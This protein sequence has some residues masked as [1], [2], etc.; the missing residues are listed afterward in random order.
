[1]HTIERIY[2]DLSECKRMGLEILG[3]DINES[4]SSF[5]VNEKGQIRCALAALKG[6]G[7]GAVAELLENRN[8]LG[9]YKNI[10]D[11]VRRVN[12]R[13]FNK[14][15]F[16][17]FALSGAFDSF[18]EH[19]R[20]QYVY[21]PNE[22][23]R[24]FI[25]KIFQYGNKFKELENQNSV[26]LFGAISPAEMTMPKAPICEEF[27]LLEKLSYEESVIGIYLSGHP[28]DP[29]RKEINA[30]TNTNLDELSTRTSGDLAFAGIVSKNFHAISK[31]GKN[32]CRFTLQDEKG[33]FDFGLY[34]EQYLKI[35]HLTNTNGVALYM[36]GRYEERIDY[37]TNEKKIE[38]R[39]GDII[40]LDQIR[41]KFTKLI[42]AQINIHDS[43][44]INEL[45]LLEAQL[46]TIKGKVEFNLEFF[47]MSEDLKLSFYSKKYRVDVSDQLFQLLDSVNGLT[48]R[49]VR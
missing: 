21:T 48:Y 35:G 7:E 32:Y 39:I 15:A 44:V 33:S 13:S 49:L 4:E 11:L 22:S 16:E 30:F 12:L 42:N 34:G 46:E 25:D 47:S 10:L 23:E 3:P 26:S 18:G 6:V 29:Y 5:T 17:A 24:P 28:L 1:M 27:G 19:H 37:K 45:L 8:K 36:T 2:F 31:A 43:V 40:L 9:P 14:K 41:E 20:A 38:F